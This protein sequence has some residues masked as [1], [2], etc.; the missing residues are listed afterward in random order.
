MLCRKY[1]GRGGPIHY[2]GWRIVGS[3]D[4]LTTRRGMPTEHLYRCPDTG[5][6]AHWHDGGAVRAHCTPVAYRH[7]DTWHD[8]DTGEALSREDAVGYRNK[9]SDETISLNEALVEAHRLK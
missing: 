1:T 5:H 7:G 4:P 8:A 9:E 2:G 3:L 6:W